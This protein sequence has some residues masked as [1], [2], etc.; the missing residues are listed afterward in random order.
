[1]IQAAAVDVLLAHGSSATA[2]V[3]MVVQQCVTIPSVLM[4]VVFSVAD[5]GI[6]S[7]ARLSSATPMAC[8]LL[9]GG[10]VDIIASLVSAGEIPM[11][12][13]MARTVR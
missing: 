9:G 7:A 2:F 3:E 11:S 13:N 1:M 8:A 12:R 10:D 6:G 5:G 4:L